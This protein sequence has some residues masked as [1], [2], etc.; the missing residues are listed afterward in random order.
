MLE[1]KKKQKNCICTLEW[2]LL[3]CVYNQFTFLKKYVQQLLFLAP[4]MKLVKII[5]KNLKYYFIY[6]TLMQ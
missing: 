3:F 1:M 5:N 6:D 2:G 4:P